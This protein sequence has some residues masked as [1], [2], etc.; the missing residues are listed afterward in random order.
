MTVTAE[1]VA[2][3][4]TCDN[5]IV[6]VL[7]RGRIDSVTRSLLVKVGI[8]GKVLSLKLE[9]IHIVDKHRCK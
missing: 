4:G 3:Q 2:S 7:E 9:N 1:A 8:R 6:T 5:K